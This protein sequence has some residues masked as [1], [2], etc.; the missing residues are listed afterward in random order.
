MPGFFLSA[1]SIEIAPHS[2]GFAVRPPHKG[3]VIYSAARCSGFDFQRSTGLRE[4]VQ[5]WSQPEA[6]NSF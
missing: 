4:P 3:E 5:G 1:L 2:D 6:G